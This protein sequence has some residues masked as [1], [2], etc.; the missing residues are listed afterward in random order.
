MAWSFPLFISSIFIL[1]YSAYKILRGYLN[2][3]KKHRYNDQKTSIMSEKPQ[4]QQ[5]K[6]R[7]N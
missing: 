7:Q 6:V 5:I 3:L 4:E 2:Y 1:G